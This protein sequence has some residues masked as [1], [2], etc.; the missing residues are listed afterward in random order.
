MSFLSDTLGASLQLHAG[1]ELIAVQFWP[2]LSSPHQ[3][4]GSLDAVSHRASTRDSSQCSASQLFLL[5]RLLPVGCASLFPAACNGFCLFWLGQLPPWHVFVAA[6]RS[7]LWNVDFSPR[8]FLFHLFH[9]AFNKSESSAVGS[10]F[11]SVTH[12]NRLYYI[13]QMNSQISKLI[14]YITV[15]IGN[16]EKV[17]CMKTMR[18]WL[19]SFR[20]VFFPLRDHQWFWHFDEVEWSRN[21][22]SYQSFHKSLVIH[23]K[24][25][26]FF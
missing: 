11:V 9:C 22:S 14:T 4:L 23:A 17:N 12:H 15:W 16:L 2:I 1:P 25:S 7:F 10:D 20:L 18:Q 8:H 5:M 21:N 19:D 26:F 13:M 3:H 24:L 6:P